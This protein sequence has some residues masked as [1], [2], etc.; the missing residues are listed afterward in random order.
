MSK[1]FFPV[2]FA[3]AVSIFII[4]CSFDEINY[5]VNSGSNDFPH[6]ITGI[7]QTDDLGNVVGGDMT[8][9]CYSQTKNAMGEIPTE[10][11]LYPAYPNASYYTFSLIYDL[12]AQSDVHI[13]IVDTMSMVS[14][15]V[16]ETQ[17]AGRYITGWNLLDDAGTRVDPGLYRVMITAGDFSCSGDIQVLPVPQP[18]SGSLVVYTEISDNFVYVSYDSPV[19]VAALWLKIIFNG[20]VGDPIYDLVTRHMTRQSHIAVSNSPDEPDTLK[21]LI[22]SPLDHLETMP[23][24]SHDLCRIPITSGAVSLDYVEASDEQGALLPA[25]IIKLP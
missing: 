12:P 5:P 14:T 13:Y 15:L 2:L 7:T 3:I 20:S 21:I 23:S 4:N 11:A 17:E 6:E 16:D 24:G 25:A 18:D 1:R 8:D 22:V 10:Y 9:W 19:D